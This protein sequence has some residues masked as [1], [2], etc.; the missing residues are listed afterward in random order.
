MFEEIVR[1]L[2][3]TLSG[4]FVVI[5]SSESPREIPGLGRVGSVHVD[6][7]VHIH[8]VARRP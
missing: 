7:D 4:V 8:A 5:T 3:P 6:G 1:A 2:P